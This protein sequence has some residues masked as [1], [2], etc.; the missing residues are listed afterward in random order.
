MRGG[1][2]CKNCKFYPNCEDL[3]NDTEVFDCGL[4]VEKEHEN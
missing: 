3:D 2:Y 1:E 4:K